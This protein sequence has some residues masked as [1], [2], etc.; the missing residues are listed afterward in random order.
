MSPAIHVWH[1]MLNQYKLNANCRTPA[2]NTIGGKLLLVF[3][4]SHKWEIKEKR[5]L[6]IPFI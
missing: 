6:H 4:F 1:K 2:P 3:E 5:M